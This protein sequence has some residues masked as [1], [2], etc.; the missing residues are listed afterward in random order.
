MSLVPA[1][2]DRWILAGLLLLP[3]G[4]VL[5]TV[6]LEGDAGVLTALVV[7]AAAGLYAAVAWL[8]GLR[9]ELPAQLTAVHPAPTGAR[10][11]PLART[12][13][14]A[15]LKAA[16]LLAVAA[17]ATAVHLLAVGLALAGGFGALAALTAAR[18]QAWEAR[19]PGRLVHEPARRPWAPAP[20]LQVF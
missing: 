9:R 7:V 4:G 10:L 17:A 12:A 20:P 2:L 13:G 11:E 3:V 6:A 1:V 19:N 8:A 18:L 14:R 15:A 5:G 16:A